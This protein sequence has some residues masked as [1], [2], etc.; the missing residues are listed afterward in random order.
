MYLS[1]PAPGDRGKGSRKDARGGFFGG[2]WM[3]MTDP[4]GS[5]GFVIE[6]YV[7]IHLLYPHMNL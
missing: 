3:V 4:Y 2:G 7:V 1:H 6:S 5:V